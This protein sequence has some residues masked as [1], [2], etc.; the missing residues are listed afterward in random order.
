MSAWDV[1]PAGVRG[2][3]ARTQSVA[4]EFEGQ[5]TAVS[6]AMESAAGNSA[7][8]IVAAALSGFAEAVQPQVRAVIARVGSALTGAA[9][10][11]NAY[12]QGD[13]EM[14]ATAQRN[15][16]GVGQPDLPGGGRVAR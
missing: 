11:V 6:G 5:L 9:T 16:A 12:A 3:L 8:P 2:V 10:A 15:A 4:G 7:S 13:L 14:A 1:D